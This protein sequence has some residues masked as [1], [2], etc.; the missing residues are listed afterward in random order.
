MEAN[1]AVVQEESPDD[2]LIIW[3]CYSCD[4]N[5]FVS[6]HPCC[7][8]CNGRNV[9]PIVDG[10]PGGTGRPIPAHSA[11]GLELCRSMRIFD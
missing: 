3:V 11:R 7:D 4:Y 5:P 9:M 1:N 10:A 8:V 6:V 2:K